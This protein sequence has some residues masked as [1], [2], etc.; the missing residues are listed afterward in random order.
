LKLVSGL[1]LSLPLKD[2]ILMFPIFYEVGEG[3]IE[4]LIKVN[5]EGTSRVT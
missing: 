2:W 5:V 3:L 4:N 1:F